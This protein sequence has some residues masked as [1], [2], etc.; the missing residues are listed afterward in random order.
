MLR[1]LNAYIALV[2]VLIVVGLACRA[3]DAKDAPPKL[4]DQQITALVHAKQEATSA[5]DKVYASADYKAFLKAQKDYQTIHAAAMK[6]VDEKKWKLG[7]DYVFISAT[8]AQAQ[9]QAQAPPA[10]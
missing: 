10:Q 8:A 7:D 1:I 3:Q 4:S 9:G 5:L 2:V 6:G